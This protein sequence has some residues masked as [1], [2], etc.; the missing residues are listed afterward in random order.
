VVRLSAVEAISG[1]E[2]FL[3]KCPCCGHGHTVKPFWRRWVKALD[4][5]FSF[6]PID[7]SQPPFQYARS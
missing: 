6:L 4:S 1:E 5:G 7:R 2:L 3:E